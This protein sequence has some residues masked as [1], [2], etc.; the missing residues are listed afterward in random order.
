[1][2]VE[3]VPREN[4]KHGATGPQITGGAAGQAGDVDVVDAVEPQEVRQLSTEQQRTTLARVGEK[5]VAE[6]THLLETT[7]ISVDEL[8]KKYGLT[9][10]VWGAIRKH[11]D[12]SGRGF[13]RQRW[14]RHTCAT[15]SRFVSAAGDRLVREVDQIPLP[16]LPIALGIAIDKL[17]LLTADRPTVV[18][19]ARLRVD[20]DALSSMLRGTK[21][22]DAEEV[23]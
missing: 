10:R 1:M 3:G 18:V 12:D 16:S 2:R 14:A 6:I 23:K 8:R 17:S 7:D 21:V 13:N 15:L 9:D 19:E 5:V 11:L 4:Y 20:A 22:I